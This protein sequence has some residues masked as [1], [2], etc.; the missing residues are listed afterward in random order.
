MLASSAETEVRAVCV[1]GSWGGGRRRRELTS[2]KKT[3]TKWQLLRSISVKED[4]ASW[5]GA[6][7]ITA[8]INPSSRFPAL[9]KS[10]GGNAHAHA[11]AHTHS[12][13]GRGGRG[14]WGNERLINLTAVG[15]RGRGGNTA[16]SAEIY[17]GMHTVYICAAPR[18]ALGHWDELSISAKCPCKTG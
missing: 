10:N 1:C 7:E 12:P 4:W 5:D 17:D 15:E 8:V 18:G 2:T 9:D 14:G 16:S 11:H 3:K 13:G 6:A